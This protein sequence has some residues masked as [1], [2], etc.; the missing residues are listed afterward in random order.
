[1]ESAV[2]PAVCI[3]AER[4][5]TLNFIDLLRREQGTLQQIDVSALAPLADE[6][7][8]QVQRLAQLADGRNRWLA[9]LG[10]SGDRSGMEHVLH[11]YPAATG[12]WNELLQLAEAAAHLNK[13]NGV[14][15]DQRLRHNQQALAVLQAAS[16]R[17]SDLY[18]SNGQPQASS[19]GRPL[20]EG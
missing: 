11:D 19:G 1:M 14:L 7:M 6:K 18:G 5:A 9:T 2:D 4:D 10:H 13:I 20:G 8:Q 15:I 16:S 3:A 12:V 17:D